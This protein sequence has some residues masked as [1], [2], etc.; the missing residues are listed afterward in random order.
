MR[1]GSRCRGA[2]RATSTGCWLTNR[3]MLPVDNLWV[4]PRLP[5]ENPV[6]NL[7]ILLGMSTT[8]RQIGHD[9]PATGDRP[10]GKLLPGKYQ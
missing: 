1:R 9:Q 10:T 7:G 4:M 2:G 3:Q 6:G 8:N 5:V